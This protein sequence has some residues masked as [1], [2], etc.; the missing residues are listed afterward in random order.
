MTRRGNDDAGQ[1][2]D[3]SNQS[4]DQRYLEAGAHIP[5]Y[6]ALRLYRQRGL[7]EWNAVIAA[8]QTDLVAEIA[9]RG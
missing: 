1:P 5:W 9:A 6:P 4:L 2:R 7:G 8:V 3:A